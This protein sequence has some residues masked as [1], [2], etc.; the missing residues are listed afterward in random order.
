MLS[1]QDQ[2][3]PFDSRSASEVDVD[4]RWEVCLYTMSYKFRERLKANH[5]LSNLVGLSILPT[6]H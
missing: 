3:I 4:A 2:G 5:H 6:D 1:I